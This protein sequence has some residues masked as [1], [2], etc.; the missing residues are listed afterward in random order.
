MH[1]DPKTLDPGLV[2]DLTDRMTYSGYLQLDVLLAAQNPLSD[3]PHHDEML[4]VIQ[5][6]TTEL[7]MK[8][9]LHELR[10]ALQ[11]IAQDQLAPC[12]KIVARI[13]HIQAHP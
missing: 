1:S 6:Q 11:L 12:F 3:P 9:V 13:Q 2:I 5:H 8:L 4:F 10:A 7:W